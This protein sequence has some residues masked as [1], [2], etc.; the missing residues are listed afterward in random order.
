MNKDK[1]VVANPN[2]DFTERY[3]T[4]AFERHGATAKGVDW[5]TEE[6]QK[7]RFEAL[8]HIWKE[9]PSLSICDFGSG[10][11]VYASHLRLAGHTGTYHGID[12]SNKMIKHAQEEFGHL[13]GVN[14]TV[15]DAPIHADLVIASGIFNVMAPGSRDAWVIHVG[16][17][18]K[19]MCQKA[20]I[21][22][23]FNMLLEPRPPYRDRSDLFWMKPAEVS[24]QLLRLRFSVEV[25]VDYG[26]HEITY[27]AKRINNEY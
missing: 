15:G 24:E 2:L 7:A 18:L 5:P 23:G 16:E 22:I 27:L 6:S 20:E 17:M 9:A 21:G 25:V 4:A 26:V 13:I 14:F 8:D 1:P 10:Y 11:G 3:Y 19:M 12:L